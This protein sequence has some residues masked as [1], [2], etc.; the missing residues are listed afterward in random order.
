MLQDPPAGVLTPTGT[1]NSIG[2]VRNPLELNP[3]KPVV[4]IS[5]LNFQIFLPAAGGSSNAP[6]SDTFMGVSA[7][8]EPEVSATAAFI[9]SIAQTDDLVF[10]LSLHSYSQLILISYGTARGRIPDHNR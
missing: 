1:S 5:C 6:C 2:I 4:T 9:Q 3:I 10:Y 7:L 8:S